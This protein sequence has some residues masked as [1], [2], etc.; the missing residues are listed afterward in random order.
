MLRRDMPPLRPWLLAALGSAFVASGA[1]AAGPAPAERAAPNADLK[2]QAAALYKEGAGLFKLGKFKE[3]GERFQAA[4]NLDPSP[5]LLYNLA[6]A[7]E[8]LGEA[9]TAVGHYKAYLARYPQAEDRAEVERRIR[10]L[11]AVAKTSAPGRL[12]LSGI[13]EG[14]TVTLNG[15][16]PP[17]AGPDGLLA[18]PAGTYVVRVVPP[19][20]EASEQTLEVRSA[21][22]TTASFASGDPMAGE[23]DTA[24]TDARPYRLWGWVGV[25]VGV[26]VAGA[27]AYFYAD[28]F[29]AA[30]AYEKYGKRVDSL[31][32]NS[33]TYDAA[34]AKL[35]GKADDE[36]DRMDRDLLLGRVLL[37]VGGVAA[38]AGVTLVVLDATRG[39]GSTTV[40]VPYPGGAGLVT[41]F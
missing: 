35:G 14:A 10:V 39:G 34:A 13:A 41:H 25:G 17:A 30:D 24:A 26:V 36:M 37:S 32:P 27:G 5:I 22:T 7:A 3:A 2:A 28:S 9:G 11:D 31:D 21:A 18:L 23:G 33:P 8:E 1:V 19:S 15:A 29:S 12:A 4:Y 38:A 20:G 16:A 6:R 40:L